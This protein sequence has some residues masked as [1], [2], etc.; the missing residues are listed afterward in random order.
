MSLVKLRP[1]QRNFDMGV[2]PGANAKDE[3]PFRGRRDFA[4]ASNTADLTAKLIG[5][6]RRA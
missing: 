2:S 6:V 4:G 5:D 3:E 1:R